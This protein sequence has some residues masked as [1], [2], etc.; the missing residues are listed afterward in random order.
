MKDAFPNDSVGFITH[1]PTLKATLCDV[2]LLGHPAIEM[3]SAITEAQMT[4]LLGTGSALSASGKPQRLVSTASLN[5]LQEDIAKLLADVADASEVN[6]DVRDFLS[7]HLTEMLKAV[8]KLRIN[9]AKPLA[10]IVKETFM[11]FAV[12]NAEGRD[13][14]GRWSTRFWELF[15][16]RHSLCQRSQTL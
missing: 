1:I 9:G 7:D 5:S 11:D 8:T 10:R 12:E 2:V 3:A 14:T 6:S 16:G 13:V 4:Q 15:T